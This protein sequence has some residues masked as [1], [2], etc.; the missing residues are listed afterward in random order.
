MYRILLLKVLKLVWGGVIVHLIFMSSNLLSKKNNILLFYKETPTKRTQISSRDLLH[1]FCPPGGGQRKTSL[2]VWVLPHA[3]N[4]WRMLKT[5]VNPQPRNPTHI[6]SLEDAV[7]CFQFTS[8]KRPASLPLGYV[9]SH[10]PCV[11]RALRT[12][13]IYSQARSELV[14]FPRRSLGRT[15][16]CP[17]MF[18]YH[19]YALGLRVR[20]SP[21]FPHLQI[22]LLHT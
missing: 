9:H 19:P 5:V 3:K 4:A 10:F 6:R 21:P 13:L 1:V 11:K 18:I 8:P 12:Q 17:P 22:S 2:T 14:T 7:S 15:L 16:T 20:A